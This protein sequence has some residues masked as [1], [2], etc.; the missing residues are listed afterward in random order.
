MQEN[1]RAEALGMIMKQCHKI[2]H[3]QDS[4]ITLHRVEAYF[5]KLVEIVAFMEQQ[6]QNAA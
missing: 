3:G 4:D 6:C 5:G 1:G 2:V